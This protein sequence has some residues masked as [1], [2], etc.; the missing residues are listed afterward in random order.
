MQG[1]KYIHLF[2][3]SVS[4]QTSPTLSPLVENVSCITTANLSIQCLDLGITPLSSQMV[5]SLMKYWLSDIITHLVP[6]QVFFCIVQSGR[7]VLFQSTRELGSQAAIFFSILLFI[8]LLFLSGICMFPPC[9]LFSLFSLPY[10]SVCQLFHYKSICRSEYL[11]GL[12]PIFSA[13]SSTSY[14]DAFFFFLDLVK[15]IKP[16]GL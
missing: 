14:R 13:Q 5:L 16:L 12:S 7:L 10:F 1:V 3:G 11:P 4:Q 9:F 2:A 6:W 8:P 15:F